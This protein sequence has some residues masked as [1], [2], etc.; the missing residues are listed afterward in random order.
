MSFPGDMSNSSGYRVKCKELAMI[1]RMKRLAA[2][3][4]SSVQKTGYRAEVILLAAFSF[5]CGT[6]KKRHQEWVDTG[7][8]VTR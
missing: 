6:G 1:K 7:R 8:A 2:Y 5:W 4:S 3:V